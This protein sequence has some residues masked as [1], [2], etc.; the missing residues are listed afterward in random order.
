MLR[1]MTCAVWGHA[2]DNRQFAATGRQCIRCRRPCLDDQPGYVRIG[3]TLSCYLRT[4]TYEPVIDRDG[5]AEYACTRCGHPL[6]FALADD[7]YRGR[8][9]FAKRVRYACGLLGH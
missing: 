2:V 4:H 6:L 7:P 9:R 8:A 3:H 1:R 5:H